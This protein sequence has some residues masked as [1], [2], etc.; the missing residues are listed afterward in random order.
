M[1]SKSTVPGPASR[2]AG[3]TPP[4]VAE[5]AH[6]GG[7]GGLHA[8]LAVLDDDTAL[9]RHAHL[10]GRVQEKVG[11]GLAVGTSAALKMRPAKRS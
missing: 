4:G 6:A 10:A 8:R 2:W 11:R 5:T 3:V 9:R 1:S 7:P